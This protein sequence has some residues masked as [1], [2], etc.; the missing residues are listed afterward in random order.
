M[1]NKIL[2]AIIILI[3][4]GLR[5]YDLGS[6]PIALNRDEA[7]LGYT[8]YSL[9][10]TGADEYG[11][12]WPLN[13]ESFGDWK[14]PVYSWFTIPSVALFDLSAW[15]VRLPSALAGIAAVGLIYHL[16]LLLI[17]K[18][19]YRY[20]FALLTA[21]LLAISP[22]H[23][24]FSRLAYEANLG[25]TLFLAAILLL[26]YYFRQP[27]PL[28]IILSGI[29]FGLTMICYHSFQL[30]TPLILITTI[31]LF[32]NK[33]LNKATLRLVVLLVASA[34]VLLPLI[35]LSTATTQQSNGVK[36]SGLSIFDQE[37]YFRRAQS[38]RQYF[39]H[40]QN[41]LA[42]YY[43]SIPLEFIR[44]L[45]VNST[46]AINPDFLFINGAGHGSHDISGIG[47][48]YSATIPFLLL[49]LATIFSRSSLFDR[50]VGLIIF[51]WLL[52]GLLPALITWQSAHA[53]RSYVIVIPLILITIQ[54]VFWT[55]Q[56]LKQLNQKLLLTTGVM[57]CII[58]LFQMGSM[59]I[60]YFI[61]AP[62]RDS[63]NW[64]WYAQDMVK[65]LSLAQAQVDHVYVQGNSWSPYIYYLFYAKVDPQYAQTHLNHLSADVEGFRHVNQ[66]DSI[67]FGDVPF[68]HLI[69][70]GNSYAVFA[71]KSQL[72]T[73]FSQDPT[74]FD[75]FE[76]LTNPNSRE[77]YVAVFKK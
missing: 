31:P 28:F 56:I 5:L 54:G 66:F 67:D 16:S 62:Q 3:A 52:I 37:T 15:S 72:P 35:F 68:Q 30:V 9:L 76:V 47:K 75:Y 25:L 58:L 12:K 26:F 8:A 74:Q 57:T 1:K 70:A 2:L 43:T 49:G 34:F 20:Q 48:L 71:P 11:K 41:F 14:L 45:L 39:T 6:T 44:Q 23:L 53:T 50:K 63:E 42:K 29:F 65:F 60:T 64:S 59:M 18:N 40:D 33:L 10:K 73:N 22:W 24:H 27:K 69:E 61:V 7:S 21:L 32:A 13:L 19:R 46:T 17:S 36:L 38:K 55:V 4:A 77:T 51:G